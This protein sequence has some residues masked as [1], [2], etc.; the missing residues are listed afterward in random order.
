MSGSGYAPAGQLVDGAGIPADATANEALRWS[1]L[2][3]ARCND[4]RLSLSNDGRAGEVVGDPTEGALLV[5]ARKAALTSKALAFPRVAAIPFSSERQF[6]ATLH[7]DIDTG[8]RVVLAKGAAE[9]LV[10]LCDGQVG[11]TGVLQPLDRD[12]ILSAVGTLAASGLR[13][14]ATA[15]RPVDASRLDEGMLSGSLVFA[16]S[17]RCSTHRVRQQPQ[18]LPPVMPRGHQGEDDHR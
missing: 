10:D 15:M 6:M 4:A 7:R 17:R 8:S 11:P 12:G 1:L 9:R 13:V 3:G 14:I 16:G 5:A 2:A 18:P